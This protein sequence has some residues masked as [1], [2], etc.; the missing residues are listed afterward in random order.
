MISK[1][2]FKFTFSECAHLIVNRHLGIGRLSAFYLRKCRNFVSCVAMQRLLANSNTTT[3][4]ASKTSD[5]RR[6]SVVLSTKYSTKFRQSRHM[7]M[8]GC[9][10]WCVSMNKEWDS[11]CSWPTCNA[12]P[13]CDDQGNTGPRA[14][15]ILCPCL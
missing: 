7:F 6:L 13:E 3:A 14:T 4:F 9:E 1:H 5:C 10:S 8:A 15:C 12:C 2:W 11:K